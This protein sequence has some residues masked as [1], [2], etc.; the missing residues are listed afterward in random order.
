MTG[1]V[2]CCKAAISNMNESIDNILAAE[3]NA[4]LLFIFSRFI[5]YH[6]HNS[7]YSEH[8]HRSLFLRGAFLCIAD[9]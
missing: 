3:T 9:K 6:L 5:L 7:V 8:L 1:T 4:V 2:W